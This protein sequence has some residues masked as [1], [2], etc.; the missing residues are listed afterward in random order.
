MI[1][2]N[3]TLPESTLATVLDH[4]DRSHLVPPDETVFVGEGNFEKIGD[5]FF[6]IFLKYGGLRPTDHVLDVGAGQ[7]RM[8]I[9][10]TRFLSTRG[11]Y[12]GVEIVKR[13]V[14]WCRN[15]YCGYPNFTFLHADV[16]NK[17]YNPH[18]TVQ[19]AA[20]EFPFPR[21][22]FDFVF[23]TSVFTH[24]CPTDVRRYIAEISRCLKPG[25]R[26]AITYFIL[27]RESLW[28][29]YSGKLGLKFQFPVFDGCL[30]TNQDDPEAAIAY[31]ESFIRE[32]YQANGMEIV[33]DIHYGSWACAPGH[34][35]FQ[36][37]VIARKT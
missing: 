25:G 14:E 13:G 21:E 18:G 17:H 36:D 32:C 26:S 33:G 2:A 23:L 3:E 6:E 24:M 27:R 5:E 15:A 1:D 20:Y 35:T 28:Q 4:G 29:I 30:T 37:V 11:S 10:L 22:R 19:A 7:G 8:A 34:L 12:T 16:F 31:P 9:P